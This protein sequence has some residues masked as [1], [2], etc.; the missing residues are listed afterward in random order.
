MENKINKKY[1]KVIIS[2]IITLLSI[3]FLLKN[4]PLYDIKKYF[5]INI[6][7]VFMVLFIFGIIKL[8]N[9]IRFSKVYNI[10]FSKELYYILCSSN[11]FLSL[12]PFRLGEL[13]YLNKLKV[14][15]QTSYS[16][17][18]T[19]LLKIRLFDYISI[20]LLLLSSSFFILNN[21]NGIIKIISIFFIISL[22]L[23]IF[24]GLLII[25]LNL[26]SKIKIE[27]IK[28]IFITIENEIKNLSFKNI[29]KELQIL[30]LSLI[31]WFVRLFLGYLLL[32]LIG[33]KLSFFMA[34]FISLAVFMLSL[35]P[36]QFVAG[37]GITE[38]GFMFFLS[39]LGFEYNL[40]II[41]LFVYHIYLLLPVLIY[42][43]AGLFLQKKYH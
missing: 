23:F 27:K 34:S 5:H 19:K 36:I 37:F 26:S 41:N 28:N 4:I 25:K 16:L 12:F 18:T 2:V 29:K 8:I 21:F 30:F 31:Y 38:A 35:I 3:Y 9:T 20:Y 22:I 6:N 43:I 7:I 17:I 13:T 40:T 33:I 15:S 10:K 39:Q 11:M 1:I 32:N 42:G 14:I 24:L